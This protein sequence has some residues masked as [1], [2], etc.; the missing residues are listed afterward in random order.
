[1]IYTLLLAYIKFQFSGL[2]LNLSR[3]ILES[4]FFR[5]QRIDLLGLNFSDPPEK[6][7]LFN[8]LY[9]DYFLPGTIEIVFII[10]RPS[11]KW[12]FSKEYVFLTV[13]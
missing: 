4:L 1:M 5:Q 6:K 12:V 11:K 9:V 7:T 10:W 13:S 3:I 2:I 8:F